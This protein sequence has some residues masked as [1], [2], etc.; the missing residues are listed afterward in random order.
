MNPGET[1]DDQEPTVK[2]KL[3]LNSA[4]ALTKSSDREPAQ[5]EM[6]PSELLLTVRPRD[7]DQ[8]QESD[9]YRMISQLFDYQTLQEEPNFGV[10]RYKN[11]LY[12]GQIVDRKRTGIGVLIYATGRVYEGEWMD[13]KRNGKGFEVYTSGTKYIGQF[14]NN[15]PHGKGVFSW[16]NGEVYDGEW[17]QGKK[18]GFGIWKGLQGDSYVG[19]WSD[20]KVEGYGVH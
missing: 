18:H 7:L 3:V 14:L 20:G 16:P 17:A 4:S 2:S 9:D 10:K 1:L 6:E 12:K 19:E 13:E 15:R 8:E 5:P 11:T